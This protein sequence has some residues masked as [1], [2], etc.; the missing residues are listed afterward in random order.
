MHTTDRTYTA[1]E[2]AGQ[3]LVALRMMR[4]AADQRLSRNGTAIDGTRPFEEVA[5]AYRTALASI[6]GMDVNA[7]WD[8]YAR[9]ARLGEDLDVVLAELAPQP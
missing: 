7:V 4:N 9:T 5:D 6:P 3:L 2:I 8:A 1:R